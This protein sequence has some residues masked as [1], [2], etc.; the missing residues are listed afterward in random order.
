MPAPDRVPRLELAWPNKDKFLLSPA[1]ET[2]KPVWV[3]RNHPG[4]VEVRLAEFTGSHGDVAKEADRVT[5]NLLFTGDSIDALRILTQHLEF[6]TAHRGKIRCAYID[7]PFN[8]GQTFTHYDDW[9]EH[10]TW[11]SFMRD[12]L[13]LI[14]QLLR[15]DGTIWVHLDNAEVHRMRCLMDEVFGARNFL[16]T[17]VWQRT[18]EKSLA[19]RTMGTM[20]ESILI[21]GASEASELRTLYLDHSPEYIAKRYTQQDARGRYDT[22]DLTVSSHR[23]HLDSGKA[24]REFDPSSIGRCWAVPRAPLLEAGLTDVEADALTMRQKLDAL[25]AAD[26]IHWP[27]GGGFPRLKRHL[28]NV[29]GRAVGDLWTDINVINSQAGERTGFST[30][31]PEALLERVLAMATD[32]GDTV[33]DCFGGSGTT[34]AVAQKTGRRWVTV[35]ALP[36][37]V[38]KLILPRLNR[39]VSQTDIGGIP[40]SHEAAAGFDRRRPPRSPTRSHHVSV[41]DYDPALVTQISSTLGLRKPNERALDALASALSD[42]EDGAELVADLATG[43][44]KT[45]IAGALLD[46]LHEQGVRNVVII[47]PGSTIQR[48]TIANLTP[49][50]PKYLRGLQS[51]PVVITLDDVETGTVGAALEDPNAFKVFVLTVQSLLRPDTKDN[52]RAHRPHEMLGQALSEYLSK[53]DDLVVIADEHHVYFSGNAKRFRA[54]INDLRPA[55]LIGLT[56]TPHESTLPERIVFHYPLADAIADGYVKIPILVARPDGVKD[57]RTQ[58]ADGVALLDAKA[59]AMKA[60]C[61][62]T[63]NE[64]EVPDGSGTPRPA[65]RRGR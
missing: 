37:T 50:S 64:Y 60:Y 5:D 38:D 11:L 30:Q 19:K 20:H 54:A 16:S 65:V 27:A 39:V 29:K 44:G 40:T 59:H 62:R 28:H 34:A 49:G 2:G 1:D 31:K 26:F 57:L 52:R 42:A 51:R 32:T 41:V 61:D 55:A 47:T 48:K 15:P 58:L 46:Y 6:R 24:W 33:L 25:D 18:T 4:A 21:Y 7:P 9:M 17:V 13:L 23:P 14:K 43:V 56:A 53:A 3:E 22:G 35:E 10:S 36:D 12:R 45:Y 8:T 63:A